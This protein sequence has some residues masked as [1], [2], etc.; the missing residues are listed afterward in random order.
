LTSEIEIKLDLTPEAVDRLLGSDLLG[1]PDQFLHQ[2]ATYFDTS[3]R[4]LFDRGFTLRIRRTGGS[5][6]QTV[7]ATGESASLFARSEWET[8]LATEQPALDH[9]SPLVSEFGADLSIG[10]QFEVEVE[11]R[12]WNV[13]ESGSKIEVVLD[14]GD[15]V[16]G[17]RRSPVREI[18]IELK[19]GNPAHLFVFAR[20]I[21]GVTPFRFGVRSKAERGFVLLDAQPRALK[22][23]RLR[24]ERGMTTVSSFRVVAA[25]C[26]RQFRLNE[27]ILMR[28]RNPEA[29]HQAR[30][31][32]RR[33][34]SAF[35]LYKP[36]LAEPSRNA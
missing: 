16:A 36:I 33:L 19:D 20:K 35:S 28:A 12:A 2:T 15:I 29:L 21:D 30:V 26:F 31:A 23:E 9:T 32:I 1:E 10:P 22:A 13:V 18:E 25:S 8:P 3:E 17:D 34:R 5:R 11:R 24:L 14:Q 7:K 4:A 6:V 27:A